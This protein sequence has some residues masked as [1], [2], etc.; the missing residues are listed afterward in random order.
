MDLSRNKLIIDLNTQEKVAGTRIVFIGCGLGSNIAVL[1][2]RTGFRDFVFCD[3]DSVEES[4]LNRQ[5]YFR[6]HI[7]LNKARALENIMY[8]INEKAKIAYRDRFI[9]DP[10]EIKELTANAGVV[11]DTADF[12]RGFYDVIDAVSDHQLVIAPFNV[13][14]GTAVTSFASQNRTEVVKPNNLISNGEH[15]SYLLR[16]AQATYSLPKYFLPL[17]TGIQ[18]S[19]HYIPQIGIAAN[20]TSSVVITVILDYLTGK[21]VPLFP[22]VSFLDLRND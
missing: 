15:F 11:I 17:F 21:R 14:Y 19:T 9:T 3:G 5:V 2:A 4:N 20:L 16:K 1:A 18:R 8:K 12:N 6:E 10:K 22:Q 13:G 7:G